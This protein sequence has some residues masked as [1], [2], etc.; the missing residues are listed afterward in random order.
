MSD[1][2]DPLGP[3]RL[4]GGR[5]DEAIDHAVRRIMSVDPPAGLRRRVLERLDAPEGAWGRVPTF[6]YAG[7][8][9]ALMVVVTLVFQQRRPE[10]P[11]ATSGPVAGVALPPVASP[12]AAAPA[13]Q[14]TPTE[15]PRSRIP[16]RPRPEPVVERAPDRR[17]SAAS[18]PDDDMA[19]VLP[20][21][22]ETAAPERPD[23]MATVPP[24]KALAPIEIAPL[25]IEPLRVDPIPP[26]K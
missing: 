20:A 4:G 21:T 5:L 23:P 18:L 12:D 6:A 9:L 22:V 24:I 25:V 1:G 11:A 26:R 10:P 14:P 13:A 2:R 3:E 17:I 7:A 16:R 15:E 8:V 19:P